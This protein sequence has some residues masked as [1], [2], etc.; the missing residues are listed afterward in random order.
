MRTSIMPWKPG[1]PIPSDEKTGSITEPESV[2]DD[3]KPDEQ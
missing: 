3:Q 1:D 2:N